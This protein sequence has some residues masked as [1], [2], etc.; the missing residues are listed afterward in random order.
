MVKSKEV[1]VSPAGRC[2][3][4]TGAGRGIG[5]AIALGLASQGASVAVIDILSDRVNAVVEGIKANGHTALAIQADVSRSADVDR[6]MNEVF[7]EFG[8]L[9]ILVNNAGGMI[10]RKR[11]AEMDEELWDRVLTANLKSTFLCSRAASKLISRPGG[12]IINISS[13]FGISGS[14]SA[15]HYS[16]AKA[17]IIGFT[18][19][20]AQELGPEGITVNAVA[21]GPT[22]TPAWRSTHAE[23]QLAAKID[24]R[25]SKTPLGRI[26]VPED[27]AAAVVFLAQRE[28]GYITGQV[29]HVNGGSLM[30]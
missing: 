22:D 23:E 6:L 12:R 27:I 17:G 20:L 26:A 7:A 11:V 16:A 24:E 13:C 28:S 19:A 25:V 10:S 8:R 9:D 2:A 30:P 4:V 21:P 29:I 3:I 14:A 5:R 1:A 18:K 15:A